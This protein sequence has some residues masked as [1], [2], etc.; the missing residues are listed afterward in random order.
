M[1]VTTHTPALA[2]APDETDAGK[3]DARTGGKR[4]PRTD[5]EFRSFLDAAAGPPSTGRIDPSGRRASRKAASH[6]NASGARSVPAT[7]E[8]PGTRDPIACT[9]NPG[10]T[11]IALGDCEDDAAS[12]GPPVPDQ[13]APDASV[14][15]IP[16]SAPDL[17]L[18]AIKADPSLGGAAA[19]EPVP[20]PD[21][22]VA[23]RPGPRAASSPGPER[24]GRRPPP[25]QEDPRTVSGDDP[26]RTPPG[27]TRGTSTT[28]DLTPS[29]AEPPPT[30]PSLNGV[31][32]TGASV[33]G[34]S[35]A[36]VSGKTLTTANAPALDAGPAAPPSRSE[37]RTHAE[38]M[39]NQAVMMHAAHGELDHPELGP[40]QVTARLRD[41]E[42]DVHLTA[43][44]LETVAILVPRIDAIAAAA[45]VPAARVEVGTR[46][47]PEF[48]HADASADGGSTSDGRS[49]G[50][51]GPDNPDAS[52]MP[53]GP[54]RVR[55]VL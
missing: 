37:A 13:G 3:S 32:A 6:G 18:P 4:L 27:E 30:G 44:R 52:P 47:E 9:C 49:P 2:S 14:P 20:R 7:P 12:P 24:E 8:G 1:N 5:S 33:L 38:S 19:N 21:A 16:D 45:N 23:S 42:V 10:S 40:I 51:P 53:A 28:R 48:A 43:H 22:I 39:L 55:I 54:R 15:P 17:S 26:P 25:V 46:G 35:S 31:S 36:D 50:E 34:A 41:G 11:V 29:R